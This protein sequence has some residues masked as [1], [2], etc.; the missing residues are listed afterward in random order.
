MKETFTPIACSAK[1]AARLCD[2]SPSLWYQLDAI[3]KVPKSMK[4]KSKRLWLYKHILL[5]AENEF[6]SRDSAEWQKI[7]KEQNRHYE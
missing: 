5:W 2:I 3:A 4:L 1:T 7:L 6:P